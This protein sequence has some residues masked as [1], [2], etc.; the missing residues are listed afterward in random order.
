MCGKHMGVTYVP[1]GVSPSLLVK[2][3]LTLYE[4]FLPLLL[5]FQAIKT[6]ATIT[7]PTTTATTA[8]T[9][10]MTGPMS[11]PKGLPAIGG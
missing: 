7:D 10:A 9:A 6:A 5:T 2:T 8:T 1:G 11:P 3:L 4:H